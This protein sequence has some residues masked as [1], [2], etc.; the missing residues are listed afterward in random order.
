MVVTVIMS[1]LV[2]VVV[3]G[4]GCSE[5]DP[6]ETGLACPMSA[7]GYEKIRDL[8]EAYG[9]IVVGILLLLFLGSHG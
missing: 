2:C 3:V 8:D 9:T 7:G 4:G 1:S 6:F 5:K